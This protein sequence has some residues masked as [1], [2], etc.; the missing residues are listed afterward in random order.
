MARRWSGPG[1]GRPAPAWAFTGAAGAPVPSSAGTSGRRARPSPG[2]SP[3]RPRWPWTWRCRGSRSLPARSPRGRPRRGGPAPRRDGPAGPWAWTS[4]RST[5]SS[6]SPVEAGRMPTR[7]RAGCLGTVRTQS[8][9]RRG[10]ARATAASPD[11]GRESEGCGGGRRTRWGV[12]AKV[13]SPGGRRLRAGR[14]PER[15]AASRSN[16][17]ARRPIVARLAGPN[18]PAASPIRARMG[19]RRSRPPHV[20]ARAIAD[21][22]P[23]L[24]RP[25][26]FVARR[27]QRRNRRCGSIR[28]AGRRLIG[29]G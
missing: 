10:I 9:G 7:W 5:R 16:R 24:K 15:R 22:G 12:G 21:V 4:D 11:L 27:C 17:A 6:L 23:Q 2:R 19:S 28:T 20:V 13:S 8:D 26:E 29:P 14:E 3:S 25:E 1:A 18:R